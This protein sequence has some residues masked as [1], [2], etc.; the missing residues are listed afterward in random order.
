LLLRPLT[1]RVLAE[2]WRGGAAALLLIL[3]LF[4]LGA[5]AEEQKPADAAAPSVPGAPPPV[6]IKIHYLTKAY[7]EPPPLSLVDPILTDKGV[8]GARLAIADNNKS[9][10]FLGQ[11]YELVEDLLPA[12]GD[13]VAKAKEIL[14][15]GP[16]IIVADLE[17]K[18]LLVVA[19]LPEAKSS[20]IFNIRL[21]DDPLRNEQ[22][23][24]NIFHI[25]PSNA[26]R[27][28]AL[29]Q[30]LIWKKWPKWLVLKGVAPS[31]KD[32]DAAVERAAGRFGGK[33]V[34]EREYKFDTANPRTD[35]G[36]SKFRRKCLKSPKAPPNTTSCGWSIPPSGSANTSLTGTTTQDLWSAPKA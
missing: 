19:D 6:E 10:A 26:M 13:V 11:K 34:E 4:A 29:A 12:D 36:I 1:G 30:Y 15:K 9:G 2:A 25:A 18:D 3:P 14:S 27:A 8:Q 24:F 5:V 33:I 7:D 28:D 16:A 31:D 22:C 35:Q 32:Y 23:R 17:A 21:S 20:I